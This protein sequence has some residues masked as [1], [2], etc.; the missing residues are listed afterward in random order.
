MREDMILNLWRCKSGA[1]VEYHRSTRTPQ[2]PFK[3]Y[4]VVLQKLGLFL[5]PHHSTAPLQKKVPKA[6]KGSWF[7]ELPTWRLR[8]RR[9]L[10]LGPRGD[11]QV[12]LVNL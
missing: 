8:D 10:L 3:P 11:L 6:Q 9:I 7:R 2:G 1:P 5:G 12:F 4:S